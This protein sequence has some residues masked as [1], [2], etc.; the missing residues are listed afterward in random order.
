MAVT[1]SA[2]LQQLNAESVD[3]IE[4]WVSQDRYIVCLLMQEIPLLILKK[5]I[6]D[7]LDSIQNY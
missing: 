1:Q 2:R 7:L 3:M 6:T 5:A 4:K